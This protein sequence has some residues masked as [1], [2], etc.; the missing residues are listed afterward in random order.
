MNANDVLGAAGSGDIG[1]SMNQNLNQ[2]QF[3]PAQEGARAY[4]DYKAGG[5]A[6]KFLGRFGGGAAEAGGAAAGEAGAAT[7]TGEVIG[8]VAELAPLA[9]L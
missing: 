6:K 1:A 5:M 4:G 9:L 7:V 2:D 3:N 8:T